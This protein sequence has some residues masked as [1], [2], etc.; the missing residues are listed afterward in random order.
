MR[1][2][3]DWLRE[4]KK[5][6]LWRLIHY[7]PRQLAPPRL[8]LRLYPATEP[9]SISIVTPSLNQGC[10]IGRTIESILD[11]GYRR[12]EYVVQDGGSCDETPRVLAAYSGRLTQVFGPDAGQADAVNRAFRLTSG[13]IM[14]YINADDMLAAGALHYV[15]QYFSRHPD[16]DAIYAHRITI[17]K[18]DREV[19][20]WIL[21]P[22]SDD[23]L[24]WADFVP[25]ETLFWRRSLWRRVGEFDVTFQFALDW[26]FLLRCV[27]AKARIVRLPRFISFFRVHERQ[28][29]TTL[30]STVGKEEMERLH[31]RYL[32]RV[33]SPVEISRRLRRYY[34]LHQVCHHA[35]RAGILRY[36]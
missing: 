3:V 7:P 14:A 2:V 20:R 15:A 1:Q 11:Q 26:D 23:A 12:L 28:K 13:E 4:K 32:G 29:T 35:Y 25:Q 18:N 36:N 10:F 19:G 22:H 24:L 27:A 34:L 21:P 17:D 16:V 30:L 5:P 33:P 6:K 9:L 8:H 31:R